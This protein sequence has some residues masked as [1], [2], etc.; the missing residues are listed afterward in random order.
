MYRVM[1]AMLAAIFS[2]RWR[3][4]L[5]GED[6]VP[7]YG[8]LDTR[9]RRGLFDE[10]DGTA[11]HCRNPLLEPVHALEMGKAALTRR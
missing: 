2:K 9:R 1:A 3:G 4:L 10:I 11:E 6:A 8:P 7:F 5:E